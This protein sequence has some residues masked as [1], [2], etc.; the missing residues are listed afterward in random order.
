MMLDFV[1]ALFAIGMKN[2]RGLFLTD[3]DN[4][5]LFAIQ[6]IWIETKNLA[7]AKVGLKF[8]DLF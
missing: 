4:A 6:W 5:N 7:L 1:N 8:K 3:I 2:M